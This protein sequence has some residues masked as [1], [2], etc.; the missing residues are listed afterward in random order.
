MRKIVIL[1]VCVAICAIVSSPSTYFLSSCV[2]LCR[3]VLFCVMLFVFCFLFCAVLYFVE[4][5][6]VVLCCVCYVV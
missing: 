4:L 3:V 5:C 2:V 6:L 1:L